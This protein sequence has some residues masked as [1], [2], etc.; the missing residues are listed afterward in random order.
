ML[1]ERIAGMKEMRERFYDLL[2]NF[3]RRNEHVDTKGGP[4]EG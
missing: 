4:D 2:N 1:D 3:D